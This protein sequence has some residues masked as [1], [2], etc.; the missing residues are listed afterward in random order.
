MV[1]ITLYAKQKKKHRFTEQTFSLCGRKG[2]W[3]VL[4]EEHLN[5][6]TIKGETDLQP[7]LDA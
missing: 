3:D 2:G 5:N 7:R 4:K 6:Y 1:T